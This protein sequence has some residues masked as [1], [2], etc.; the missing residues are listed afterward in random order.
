MYKYSS[1]RLNMLD[2]EFIEY[3]PFN[4]YQYA[5]FVMPLVNVSLQLFPVRIAG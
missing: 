2:D 4:S 3:I 5:P 1:Y